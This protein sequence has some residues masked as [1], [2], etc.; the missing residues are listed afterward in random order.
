M[1]VAVCTVAYNE[2]RFIKPFINHIPDWVEEVTVL[3]SSSPWFG[4]PEPTDKTYQLARET[5]ATVV[6]ND[7]KTEEE[8]RNT[9]LALHQD[10]D[11]IIWLDP[12]EFLDDHNWNQLKGY[13][14]ISRDG[15]TVV[16]GQ[17]TYWKDGWVA[18]PPKDY[19]MLIATRPHVKFID[20]R[21]VNCGFNV[22]PI[23]LHHF[24]WARTDAEVKKKITHYA[25]AKD[26]D[27]EKWYTD[28]WLKWKPG[29]KNVH[30]TSPET[31]HDFEKA[32]LPPELEALNL[33]PKV[34]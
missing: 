14:E 32:N 10:K 21:V 29:V 1:K 4:K 17:N 9:G 8:Q 19:Q 22:A 26:F 11:W 27:T 13:L 23:W 30:P 5:R 12:D 6:Q 3:L 25:H 16:E 28:V 24:S 31:L 15:A 7:W 34:A 18:T 20:K 33:W 2:E